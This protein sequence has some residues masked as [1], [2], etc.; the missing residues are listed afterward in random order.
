MS[1]IVVVQRGSEIAIAADSLSSY[2]S[3][4]LSAKY[5]ASPGKIIT[6]AG[7][8]FGAVGYAANGQV[9]ESA[10]NRLE[11][12]LRLFNDTRAIFETFRKLHPIL[13]T[14][15]YLVTDE[16]GEQPYE[17]SQLDVLIANPHG[18]FGVLAYREVFQYQRFWATGTGWKFALGAM[19]ACYDKESSAKEI[20]LQG[21]NA[22]CE[23][24]QSSSQPVEVVRMDR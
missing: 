12:E 2:G 8:Y 15:Y 6:F 22:A 11:P 18:I 21:V 5:D 1:T 10:L 13:K 3:T 24:D 7:S 20:A 17:S 9:L 16:E 14:D 23:F 19:S 4:N